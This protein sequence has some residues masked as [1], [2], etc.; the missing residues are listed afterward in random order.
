MFVSFPIQA[1]VH[2]ILETEIKALLANPNLLDSINVFKCLAFYTL[3]TT[4]GIAYCRIVLKG[5]W[6]D[7][8]LCRG[9]SS[10]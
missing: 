1:F 8:Q 3:G 2:K 9:W 6:G 10:P 4:Q 7:P 5:A